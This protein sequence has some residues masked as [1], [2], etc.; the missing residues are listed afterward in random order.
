MFL[1]CAKKVNARGTPWRQVAIR[2]CISG[3]KNIIS[4]R[5]ISARTASFLFLYHSKVSN[6]VKCS[7]C[8]RLQGE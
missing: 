5:N 7:G 3:A 4:V 8:G 6:N 2:G 1:K